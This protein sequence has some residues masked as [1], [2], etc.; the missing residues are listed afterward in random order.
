MGDDRVSA[1]GG[2]PERT[3]A[4]YEEA[5]RRQRL[6]HLGDEG[7]GLGI[8]LHRVLRDHHVVFAVDVAH[9]HQLEAQAVGE[10]GA[11]GEV[12]LGFVQIPGIEVDAQDLGRAAVG[13][14]D[15]GASEPAADVED[16]LPL[17]LE[18]VGHPFEEAAGR[19]VP[20]RVPV[21]G[22]VGRELLVS[23]RHQPE[24][25]LP[26]AV[27]AVE[28]GRSGWRG[29]QGELVGGAFGHR[30]GRCYSRVCF[31]RRPPCPR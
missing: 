23:D 22:V 13:D 21:R 10:V 24:Q 6:Q 11:L 14:L 8:V 29:R 31:N 15:A 27:A 9:V 4:D 18:P 12:L 3:E 2:L 28:D 16:A 17:E 20:P 25:P 30:V 26:G 7:L 19:H 1:E 5:A